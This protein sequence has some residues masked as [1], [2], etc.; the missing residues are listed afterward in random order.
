MTKKVRFYTKF[1]TFACTNWLVFCGYLLVHKITDEFIP[2]Y[3]DTEIDTNTDLIQWFYTQNGKG[4]FT[5]PIL[6]VTAA[7]N[8]VF[9]N[10]FYLS[11]LCD[12]PIP[13]IVQ[14]FQYICHVCRYSCSYDLLELIYIVLDVPSLNQLVI[15]IQFDID[16]RKLNEPMEELLVFL[17][18]YAW[19][20]LNASV[21]I[22]CVTYLLTTIFTITKLQ[23]YQY[24]S[25]KIYQ[26]STHVLSMQW[27]YI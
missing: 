19:F 10:I 5:W 14:F 26:F 16:K 22:Y 2:L 18:C 27:G 7:A 6:L 25:L 11:T 13:D 12:G 4:G 15:W 24:H 9:I 21:N 1:K 20:Y 8:C 3:G 23:Q 17:K